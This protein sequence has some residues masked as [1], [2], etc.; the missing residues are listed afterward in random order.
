MHTAGGVRADDRPDPVI[1]EPTDAIVR[2]TA[3]CICGRF[4]DVSQR[5]A[6]PPVHAAIFVVGRDVKADRRNTPTVSAASIS[7]SLAKVRQSPE[8]VHFDY[9]QRAPAGRSE[10]LVSRSW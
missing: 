10:L 6:R 5:R 7:R 3:T 9:A 8:G 1:E 2:L 4:L